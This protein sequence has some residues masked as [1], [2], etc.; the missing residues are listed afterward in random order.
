MPDV[1]DNRGFTVGGKPY[2]AWYGAGTT[3]AFLRGIDALY[4][5]CLAETHIKNLNGEN[6][7]RAA[8]AL[9]TA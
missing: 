4:F 5:N 6:S 8:I 7:Q 2:C 3:D 9:R 1:I